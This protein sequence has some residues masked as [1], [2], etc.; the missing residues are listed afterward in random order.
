M[1]I[2]CRQNRTTRAAV[3]S[4]VNPLLDEVTSC[5]STSST[6]DTREKL[7]E[8]SAA[9]R[10]HCGA[11]GEHLPPQISGTVRREGGE[12]GRGVISGDFNEVTRATND[13]IY[14]ITGNAMAFSR[15]TAAIRRH[16]LSH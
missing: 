10:E 5:S 3:R 11:G 7:E 8:R 12:R 4:R 2:K 14:R 15:P 6:S 13:T 16:L 1:T 9:A